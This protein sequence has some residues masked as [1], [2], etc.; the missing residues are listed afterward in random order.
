MPPRLTKY[1]E[2]IISKK[3]QTMV[4]RFLIATVHTY[5]KLSAQLSNTIASS[6]NK[7]IST[8]YLRARHIKRTA[9]GGKFTFVTIDELV[10]WTAE[11]IKL[12]PTT[13]DLIVGIPRSGLLVA[14]IVALKLGKPFTTPELFMQNHYWKSKLINKKEYANIL[15][16]DDSITSGKAMAESCQILR[17]YRKNLSIT[18]AALIATDNSKELVDLYYKIIPHPRIFE[19][20]LLHAKKGKIAS[21]L[22]GVICEN[23]PPG[24]DSDEHSYA[25]WIKNA[26]P[27]LI[28]AFEIDVIVSNRLEKYRA[29]TENWLSKHG[30][31]Y[32]E[33]ILWGIQSK[34]ERNGRHAQRKI[35][36]LLKIKPELF[37]ESSFWE[38]K[39]IWE[40]TKIPVLC[41]DEMILLD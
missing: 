37:W 24:V 8:M 28:P 3:K 11:W 41:F 2:D 34:K 20:N 14:N 10:R 31:R 40:A 16:I 33:L 36:V 23:C 12:F 19:W 13:Y 5:T 17:S 6:N 29:E 15:L 27:Y 26:K 30:V 32:K 7:A 38:A 1:L 22:D 25:E 18:K 39:Q 4:G 21:D 9:A 35:G